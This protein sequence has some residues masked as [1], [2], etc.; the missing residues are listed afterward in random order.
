M[1][2]TEGPVVQSS[3]L[4]LID[5]DTA[6]LTKSQIGSHLVGWFSFQAL[7]EMIVRQQPDLLN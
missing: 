2:T 3:D 5:S 7:Y 1:M 4:A 6:R